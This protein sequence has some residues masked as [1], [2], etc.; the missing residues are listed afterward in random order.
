MFWV[1][2]FPLCQSYMIKEINP[3][4]SCWSC[5][6]FHGFSA[7]RKQSIC[8]VLDSNFCKEGHIRIHYQPVT[9][10]F[11][12]R[13]EYSQTTLVTSPAS[14]NLP[15]PKLNSLRNL[16]TSCW[17][18]ES[19]PVQHQ[20]TICK[21]KPRHCKNGMYI[22]KLSEELTWNRLWDDWHIHGKITL[23]HWTWYLKHLSN[24]ANSER[25]LG[26]GIPLRHRIFNFEFCVCHNSNDVMNNCELSQLCNYGG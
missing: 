24:Q 19:V 26:E 5:G 20:I 11:R 17:N 25:I 6:W 22:I 9:P 10:E 12:L 15:F 13:C 1:P 3:S 18:S 2:H 16:N 14:Q 23:N 4:K 7:P 8:G 21:N